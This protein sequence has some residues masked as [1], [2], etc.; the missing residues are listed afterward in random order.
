MLLKWNIPIASFRERLVCRSLK[1]HNLSSRGLL[2]L[3]DLPCSC[4]LRGASLLLS[5]EEG[6]CGI[7]GLLVFVRFLGDFHPSIARLGGLTDALTG[8]RTNSK[9]CHYSR[10]YLG[11]VELSSCWECGDLRVPLR[12]FFRVFVHDYAYAPA[13]EMA[14]TGVHSIAQL[15][16]AHVPAYGRV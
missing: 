12:R 4:C 16:G 5:R 15:H 6:W 2:C 3:E 13:H 1:W 14:N 10:P 11:G 9:M 8:D 7:C